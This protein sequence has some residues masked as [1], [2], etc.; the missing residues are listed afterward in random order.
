MNTYKLWKFD[1]KCRRFAVAIQLSFIAACAPAPVIQDTGTVFYPALP[2]SP[3][4]QFL[5]SITSEEDLGV[6]RNRFREFVTGKAET[7]NIVAR[8]WDL[9]HTR[10]KLYVSDKTYRRIVIVNLERKRIEFVDNR[11]GGALSNPGGIFVDAAGY[12][13][14]A[15]RNRGEIVV[16]DQMDRFFRAYGSG[17][18]FNPTDVVVFGGRIYA[19]DVGT[20]TIQIFDRESGAVVDIIGRQGENE[21]TFRFPTHLTIDDAGNLFV[22][23]FLNFRVQK[24]DVDGNFVKTIGEPGDFPGAMPRPKGIDVDRDGRLY[25]VDSAFEIVQIF[26]IE[27]GSALMPF[28]K[29]GSINGGTWLPAGVH[30]DY[31]NISY[32]SEYL[33]PN[34]RAE[35]LIYVTNQSG[36]FKINVYAFGEYVENKTT[37]GASPSP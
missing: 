12:K 26:D 17:D 35:Y 10:G 19:S 36:P 22:T 23:D 30:I 33:D 4:I 20:E 13:Y 15:D 27:T 7:I 34:F 31:D 37:V 2:D 28:G 3:R 24:F 8:P 1:M 21:G 29:F 25:A 14:I 5:T 32:F 9:D 6:E 16:F 11:A 18:D